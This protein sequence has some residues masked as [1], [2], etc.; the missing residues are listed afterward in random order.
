MSFVSGIVGAVT[1]ADAS[2]SAANTQ[3]D[4]SKDATQIQL[5]MYEEGRQDTAPW[6][7]AGENALK[8][9]QDKIATGPGDYTKSPGYDFRLGEGVKV[10]DR[11]GSAKGNV[12]S[13]AQQKALTRYGQDYGTNDYQ[14]FLANY[15]QSL[16]PYQSLAGQG[17]TTANT[18]ATQGN[19]V[20]ANI[21]A[22][23]INSGNAQAAGIMNANNAIVG[24]L[25]NASS[26][27][28]NNY[29]MW[30]YL[31]GAG[32]GASAGA[33]SKLVANDAALGY[34]SIGPIFA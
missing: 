3:A 32:A 8:T 20:G 7:E 14:N 5:Q 29:M 27:G 1:G 34:E 24:N 4:A 22:N 2:R 19:Q 31:N 12:L 30:K 25:S 21:G 9:L 33:A 26:A 17:M 6:R 28:V 16:T 23:T 18:A 11:S 13:G 15:Y 10:L